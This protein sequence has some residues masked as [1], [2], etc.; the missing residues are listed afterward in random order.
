VTTEN[1]REFKR[2]LRLVEQSDDA[3]LQEEMTLETALVK[4]LRTK[5]SHALSEFLR[6]AV[7]DRFIKESLALVANKATDV[8]PLEPAVQSYINNNFSNGGA[9]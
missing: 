4:F 3:L 1:T 7:T 5:N 6:G 8:Q 2:T 9:S